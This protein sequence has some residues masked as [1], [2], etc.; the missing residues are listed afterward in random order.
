MERRAVVIDRHSASVSTC[1]NTDLSI[2][3]PMLPYGAEEGLSLQD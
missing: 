1:Q 3:L 2:T